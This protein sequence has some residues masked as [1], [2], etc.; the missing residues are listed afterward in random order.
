M[1]VKRGLE[2]GVKE[3]RGLINKHATPAIHVVRVGA[4]SP[5]EE[6]PFGGTYKVVDGNTLPG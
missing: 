3:T 2:F 5:G 4:T 1:G 6:S